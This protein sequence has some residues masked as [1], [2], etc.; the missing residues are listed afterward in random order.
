MNIVTEPRPLYRRFSGNSGSQRLILVHGTL[1]R[2]SSFKRLSQHLDNFDLVSYDRRGYGNSSVLQNSVDPQVISIEDH[3]NDLKEIVNEKPCVVFG[4]SLGG[5]IALI[6]ASRHLNNICGLVVFEP[7]LPWLPEWS[8]RLPYS[9]NIS[10]GIDIKSAED[11]AEDFI[12]RLA[13]TDVWEKLA[14]E[15]KIERRKEGVTMVS[16]MKTLADLNPIP[17][18]HSIAVPVTLCRSEFAES[19]HVV[20]C[21]YLASLLP[22]AKVEI[23]G[24]AGHSAHITQPE[25]VASIIQKFC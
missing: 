8:T 25:A 16:E 21:S 1:D 12:K 17:D 13:G 24:D 4:H 11:R 10:Q 22:D 14:P 3:I 15:K 19:R 23:V 6:A 9:M 7:P 2:S 5:T 18:F 20:G